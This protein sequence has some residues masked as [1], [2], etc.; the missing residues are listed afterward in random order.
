MGPEGLRFDPGRNNIYWSWSIISGIVS[1][2][3]GALIVV[4]WPV[5]ALWVIG[6]FVSLEM[7]FHGAAA[8]GL[9]MKKGFLT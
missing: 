4:Q 2:V 8:L 3:L 7:L 5:T 1:V 9:S 6:L